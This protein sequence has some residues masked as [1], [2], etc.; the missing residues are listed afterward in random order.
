MSMVLERNICLSSADLKVVLRPP[1]E[2]YDCCMTKL[3][4]EHLASER[5]MIRKNFGDTVSLAEWSVYG[6]A[7]ESVTVVILHIKERSS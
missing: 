1:H 2:V 7:V 5:F 3:D 4:T 6:E